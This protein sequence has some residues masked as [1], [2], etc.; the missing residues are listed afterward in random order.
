MPALCRRSHT[1]SRRR[2]RRVVVLVA[3]VVA[4]VLRGVSPCCHDMLLD[5]L[6]LMPRLDGRQHRRPLAAHAVRVTLH[7]AEVRAHRLRQVHLE[8]GGGTGW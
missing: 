7:H 1:R 6:E 5:L 2:G 8:E 4:V 3:V